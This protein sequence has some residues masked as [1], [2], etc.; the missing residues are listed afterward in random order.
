M[1]TYSAFTKGGNEGGTTSFSHKVDLVNRTNVIERSDE[2]IIQGHPPIG[3][4]TITGKGIHIALGD[5]DGNSPK[6]ITYEKVR[7]EVVL[8]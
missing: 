1:C 6:G 3:D 7:M 5:I 2:S 4:Y 8:A